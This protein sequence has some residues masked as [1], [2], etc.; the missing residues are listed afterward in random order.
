MKKVTGLSH[1]F[2][3]IMPSDLKEGTIYVSIEYATVAHRCCC[4]CGEEV[5]TP[6]GPTD[7]RLIYDGE[8]VSLDPSIGNWSFGCKSHYWITGNQVIWA[9]R[10]SKKRI[11]AGRS[12]DALAKE[13]YFDKT[14]TPTENEASACDGG[15]DEAKSAESFGRKLKKW[16]FNK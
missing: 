9:P 12:H 2:V 7:W 4:G 10:W 14:K 8:T 6:L 16:W 15:P 1:E 3:E 13:R 11:E 5:V